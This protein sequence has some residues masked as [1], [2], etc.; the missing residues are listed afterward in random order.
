MPAEKIVYI[1]DDDAGVRRSLERLLDSAGLRALSYESP[2]AF[3]DAAV[4][5][6]PGAFCS[7]FGCL[8]WTG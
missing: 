4:D 3:L 6:L 8:K 1:V 2:L 7:T 5:C